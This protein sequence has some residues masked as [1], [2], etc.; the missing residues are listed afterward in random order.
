MSEQLTMTEMLSDGQTGAVVMSRFGAKKL[1]DCRAVLEV[2][3]TVGKCPY[4]DT[5][6]TVQFTAWTQDATDET[7]YADS[8]LEVD[9][10]TEPD[11][12][13]DEFDE[14]LRQHTYM[15]YVFMLPV[16]KAIK[17]WLYENYRFKL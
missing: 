11:I 3:E 10:E 15:P 14:W 4:C 7:W 6:L 16:H 13:S 1:L 17:A 8:G 12:E 9:C 5:K 2:P